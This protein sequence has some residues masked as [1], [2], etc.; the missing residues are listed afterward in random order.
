MNEKISHARWTRRDAP[1]GVPRLLAF[2][3]PSARRG[4]ATGRL[5]VF[6]REAGRVTP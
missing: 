5:C 1:T 2:V 6:L 3:D 4:R